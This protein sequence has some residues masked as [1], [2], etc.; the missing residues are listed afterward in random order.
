MKLSARPGWI[1]TTYVE[2]LRDA[3]ADVVP[4]LPQAVRRGRVRSESAQTDGL[5]IH[6]VVI[7]VDGVR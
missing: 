1:W 7:D 3:G 4:L 6:V 5:D 2:S